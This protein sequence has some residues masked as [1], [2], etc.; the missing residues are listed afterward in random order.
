MAA[1]IR[2]LIA[3]DS[4]RMRRAI[5]TLL[6]TEPTITVIGE[7]DSYGELI[8]TLNE[9]NPDVILMDVHMPG[10]I[11]IDSC[12]ARLS[13]LCILAMSFDTNDETASLAVSFGATKLLDKAKLASDLVPAVKECIHQTQASNSK[14]N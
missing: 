12:K 6:K 11:Q 8:S 4:E 2:L 10:L 9:S 5:R 7:A 3:D 13:G 14:P 1:A